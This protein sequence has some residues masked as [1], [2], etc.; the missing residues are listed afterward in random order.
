MSR[1]IFIGDVHGMWSELSQLL[2]KLRPKK[3]DEVIFVGDLV[4]KGFNSVEVVK[5]V[6]SLSESGLYK[7]VVVEGNHESKHKRYRKHLKNSPE[8]A[9]K[10]AKNLP[11]LKTITKEL[12]KKD[13]AF[14]DSFPMFY[15]VPRHDI[16][17]VHGGIPGN[18]RNFPETMEDIS[19][20]SGKHR[21]SFKLIQF[22]RYVRPNGKFVRLGDE[23]PDDDFWASVY[24]GRFG[25]VVFGH[26]PFKKVH[27]YPHATGIDTGA[28]FGQKL[29]ALVINDKTGKRSYVQ[30]DSREACEKGTWK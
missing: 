4:D 3:G 1:T 7:I 14:M 13:I 22:A 23:Q 15:R 10:M 11:E 16:L 26:Q 6:R 5:L 2:G 21:K 29:T 17:V 18:F 20:M 27:E 9:K 30:V 19:K 24:D 25:H 8:T 12:S 28:V